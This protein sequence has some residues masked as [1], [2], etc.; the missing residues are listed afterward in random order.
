M[1]SLLHTS[2]GHFGVQVKGE[3]KNGTLLNLQLLKPPGSL[4]DSVRHLSNSNL[5]SELQKEFQDVAN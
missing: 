1:F 2:E 4:S 5:N 3:I